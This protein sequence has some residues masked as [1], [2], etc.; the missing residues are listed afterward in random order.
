MPATKLV[1]TEP[2]ELIGTKIPEQPLVDVFF[3]MWQDENGNPCPLFLTKTVNGHEV[4]VKAGRHPQTGVEC[5]LYQKEDGDW[6]PVDSEEIKSY[7]SV[8]RGVGSSEITDMDNDTIHPPALKCMTDIVL[9]FNTYIAHQKDDDHLLGGLIEIPNLSTRQPDGRGLIKATK[10]YAVI[11]IASDVEDD[12]PR[13][14]RAAKYIAK[15]RRFGWSAGMYYTDWKPKTVNGRKKGADVYGLLLDEFSS[16]PCPSNQQAWCETVH[17]SMVRKGW[18]PSEEPIG[19]E[20]LYR[21][22]EK[23]CMDFGPVIGPRLNDF[24]LLL[25]GQGLIL[26]TPEPFSIAMS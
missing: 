1:G 6:A 9:P 21:L 10:E 3:E 26:A 8:I 2:P 24:R 19:A 23:N 14:I 15:G 7:P 16:T 17:K 5:E 4:R 20:T 22:S 12:N 11:E 13:A 18:L 25:E